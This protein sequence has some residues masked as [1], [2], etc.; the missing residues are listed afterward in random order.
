M[1]LSLA[2]D[3]RSVLLY[4]GL[5]LFGDFFCLGQGLE[6]LGLQYEFL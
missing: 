4:D 1:P 6:Y 3:L 2:L 5:G